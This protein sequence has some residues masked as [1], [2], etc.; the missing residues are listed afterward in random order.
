M[1][2]VQLA[3]SG[4]NFSFNVEAKGPQVFEGRLKSDE[5]TG[6]LA[7][8]QAHRVTDTVTFQIRTSDGTIEYKLTMG[9]G[10]EARLWRITPG[11]TG[12]P[13]ELHEKPAS[14]VSCLARK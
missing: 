14:A 3:R 2:P 9:P 11:S 10:R 1:V 4:D 5:L 8:L 7:I 6:N 12:E 13:I